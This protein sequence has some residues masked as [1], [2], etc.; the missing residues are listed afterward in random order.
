MVL[1]R[2]NFL[3]RQ[4]LGVKICVQFSVA[5]FNFIYYYTLQAFRDIWNPHS[6]LCNLGCLQMQ[7]RLVKTKPSLHFHSSM[8]AAEV[9]KQNCLITYMHYIWLFCMSVMHRP[10]LILFSAYFL[11]GSLYRLLISMSPT[12]E[13]QAKVITLRERLFT[14]LFYFR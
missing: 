14:S 11:T 10:I 4:A 3:S 8:A 1:W 6:V 7:S 12:T 13:P 5:N 9:L 2:N